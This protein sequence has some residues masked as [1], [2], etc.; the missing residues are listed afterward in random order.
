MK[1]LC[2]FMSG[3]VRVKLSGVF[4]AFREI[5]ELREMQKDFEKAWH[6]S[7][8]KIG[9]FVGTILSLILVISDLLNFSS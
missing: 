2:P 6:L 9:M 5:R 7:E 3:M 8:E 4:R 1:A